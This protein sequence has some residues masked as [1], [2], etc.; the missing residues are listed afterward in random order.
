[1]RTLSD[2]GKKLDAGLSISMLLYYILIKPKILILLSH[3]M[4]K[5]LL[6]KFLKISKLLLINFL[7]IN[8]LINLL[9]ISAPE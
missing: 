2:N 1:M 7:C 3:K 8:S 9:I 6:K 4:K 5:C